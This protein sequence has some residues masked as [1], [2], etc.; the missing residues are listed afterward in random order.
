MIRSR[1]S[2]GRGDSQLQ[3]G[4]PRYPIYPKTEQLAGA[5]AALGC[6]LRLI[7]S[8]PGLVRHAVHDLPRLFLGERH[9]LG[10]SGLLIP[11]REAIA[12]ETCELHQLDLLH[13]VEAPQMCEEASK[14][15]SLKLGSDCFGHATGR[16]V[17]AIWPLS[18]CDVRVGAVDLDRVQRTPYTPRLCA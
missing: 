2:L 14:G 13:V 6:D 1:P 7:P 3:G 17:L 18:R 16:G 8:L 11:I 5:V 4:Q 10:G 9:T 15:F 12:A